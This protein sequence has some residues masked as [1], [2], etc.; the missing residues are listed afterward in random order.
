VNPEGHL[1][2]Q[3]GAG[4]VLVEEYEVDDPEAGGCPRMRTGLKLGYEPQ[5]EIHRLRQ[6]VAGLQQQVTELRRA[7]VPEP[8]R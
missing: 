3:T 5:D 6:T 2:L 7:L 1:L 4:L 8:T